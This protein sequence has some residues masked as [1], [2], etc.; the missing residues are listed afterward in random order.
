M[1]DRLQSTRQ[2]GIETRL[3]PVTSVDEKGR[4]ATVVFTTGAGVK[5]RDWTTG[6]RYI[7]ELVV[8]PEAVDL[9]RLRAGAP[10]LNTHSQ[11]DVS[12]VL[13]VVVDARIVDGEGRATIRFSERAE[14]EPVFRD[15]AAGILRNVS[16]GYAVDKIER[17]APTDQQPLEIRRV[18][19]W[20]PHEISLVP[21]GADPHA[22]VR[23]AER[24]QPQKGPAMNDDDVDF[25]D[26]E[27]SELAQPEDH[28]AIRRE[29]R[30]LNFIHDACRRHQ[31]GD[32]FAQRMIADD[33]CDLPESRRRVLN[34]LMRR[35]EGGLGRSASLLGTLETCG[36][37]SAD[38]EPPTRLNAMVE[39]LDARYNGSTPS[40]QARPYCRVRVVDMAR[41]LLEL[42]SIRTGSMS[43][44]AVVERAMTTSDLP[45]LLL[46]VGNRVLRAA[47]D[48]Y[49]GGILQI[50]RQTTAPDFRAKMKLQLG[51]APT[52]E[53]VLEDGVFKYGSVAEAK[54]SYALATYGKIVPLSRQAIIN[55]ELNAFADL[56]RRMGRAAREFEAQQIV[57]LLTQS[58]GAGPTMGDGVALFH[59]N[60]GNLAASGGAIN[61]TTLGAARLVMRT[62]KGLD[63][64]TPIDVRPKYLVVPAAL[65]TIAEQYLTTIAANAASSANPFS[66]QLTLVVDPRLD[67][68]SATA[69]YVA[70]ASGQIDTLEYAYLEEA[71]GP[72]VFTKEGWSK[73]GMEFK[74]RLDFGCAAID[75][76]GLY[77]NPG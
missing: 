74:V 76:R 9:S 48:T 7:E 72:Q 38:V 35:Q 39:A 40:E 21:V 31:L 20:T 63:G 1:N 46:G 64:K 29:R 75:W 26:K 34:E 58:A 60:H 19:R 47:Y 54:E 22:G 5:R 70:A 30:R 42:H 66:G 4:S 12:D 50:A 18:T 8:T 14:V 43:N 23:S 59:A 49:E 13:G 2:A 10:L 3:M 24:S 57:N 52:L 37:R 69:W 73:D 6:A 62:Q 44:D 77:R 16:V 56:L 51:E 25:E 15:V 45:E 28:Q 17:I 53:K 55:D 11:F 33:L 27:R 67:A 32:D 65:E 36:V 68:V 41:E 71:Q 61:V